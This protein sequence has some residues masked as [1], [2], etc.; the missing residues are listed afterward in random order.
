MSNKR[1]PSET[2]IIRD[3]ERVLAQSIPPAWSLKTKTEAPAKGKRIDLLVEVKS[4]RA[5][6]R[7]YDV[8]RE[9]EASSV[10]GPRH[11]PRVPSPM[12]LTHTVTEPTILK[13]PCQPNWFCSGDFSAYYIRRLMR[14]VPQLWTSRGHHPSAQ[15]RLTALRQLSGLMRRSRGVT[16]HLPRQVVAHRRLQ[17][18]ACRRAPNPTCRSRGS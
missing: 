5:A 2:R 4:P 12:N 18:R 7:S 17:M 9:K 14:V 15:R 8:G 13:R 16:R 10:S 6:G 11:R 3:V 1:P